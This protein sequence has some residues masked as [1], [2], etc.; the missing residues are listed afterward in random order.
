MNCI[1]FCTAF[2][3]FFGIF[4]V[5]LKNLS[6]SIR[7][8]LCYL[9][10]LHALVMSILLE[11]QS[12]EFNSRILFAITSSIVSGLY[13]HFAASLHL[14]KCTPEFAKFL[15]FILTCVY[16]FIIFTTLRSRLTGDEVSEY[17]QIYGTFVIIDCLLIMTIT[18]ISHAAIAKIATI[19]R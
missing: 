9:R 8:Y 14:R 7:I 1:L 12:S 3:C 5:Y 15:S 4:I 10:F 17:L 19:S 13:A 11:E 16:I 2:H 6:R 18:T